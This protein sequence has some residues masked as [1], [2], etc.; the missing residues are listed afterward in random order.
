MKILKGIDEKYREAITK[1]AKEVGLDQV[2]QDLYKLYK[3]GNKGSAEHP[4]YTQDDFI[5]RGY[6]SIVGNDKY[7]WIVVMNITSWWKT[8]PVLK[9]I[10]TEKGFNIE[11][12]NSFYRLE[13]V[14]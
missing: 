14:E 8:S 3:T 7:V 5:E 6:V 10:K 13:L 11:T 4:A 12:E 9:C 1:N 2:D